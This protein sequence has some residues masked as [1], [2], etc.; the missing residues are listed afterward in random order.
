MY[1]KCSSSM[2][3]CITLEDLVCKRHR[4]AI[5]HM[6]SLSKPNTCHSAAY[7]SLSSSKMSCKVE[8]SI[9][10]CS[11]LLVVMILSIFWHYFCK[12]HW[13]HNEPCPLL[14]EPRMMYL[15]GLSIYLS[16]LL[17]F[18]KLVPSNPNGYYVINMHKSS[19]CN[20]GV[21]TALDQS[22]RQVVRPSL[23]LSHL[24]L[25]HNH[26]SKKEDPHCPWR[27]YGVQGSIKHVGEPSQSKPLKQWW[28]PA[29]DH[30]VRMI[31]V[32]SI[33]WKQ[34]HGCHKHVIYKKPSKHKA[35]SAPSLRCTSS[36][37]ST[38]DLDGIIVLA[39]KALGT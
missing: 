38:K 23:S 3:M 39:S 31:K 13:Q 10:K 36:S 32:E 25:P 33:W 8:H 21:D 26:Y 20:C 24:N 18:I 16:H 15:I 9:P 14:L 37:T 22:I 34:W 27:R 12:R 29:Y 30:C 17:S 5:S 35:W 7:S 28:Q 11:T 6:F 1:I 2:V 19:F 4:H